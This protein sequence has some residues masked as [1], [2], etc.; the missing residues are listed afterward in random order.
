[1]SFFKL[2]RTS[3]LLCA[4]ALLL[5]ACGIANAATQPVDLDA[6]AVNGAES[7][8]ELNVLA[9]FPVQIEN[10]VTNRTAGDAFT[11]SWPSA[12]PG[13]FSSSV[14][15]GTAGGVGA[16]WVWTTNQSVFAFTGASCV[17]DACFAKTSGPDTLSGFCSDA[18]LGDATTINVR[19]GATLGTVDISWTGGTGTF[20][21]FR[22]T[23]KIAVVAP[24]NSVGT[25][26]TF[27]FTDTPPA[28]APAFY[29]VRGTDCSQRKACASSNDCSGPSDGTCISRGPFGVPGR[30]LLAN[31]V[32]V[33][34]ASLTS[35]LITFF[36]PPHT[37]F[38]ATSEGNAGGTLE[39]FANSSTQPLTVTVPAYPPGCCPAN[40]AVPHQLRCGDTCVDYLN[41]PQNCGSC[42]NVCGDGTC[43]SNG[44]C[45][46]LCGDDRRW[47][48]GECADLA[49][50]SNSCGA[51]GNVC[52]DGTCCD[53]A[54]CASICP[55]GQGWCDNHC[56]DLA[57]DSANCGIC[58]S[59]CGAG[60]CCNGGA[61]ASVCPAWRV[62]CN[63]QCVD[64]AND[65]ANCGACGS[66][67]GAGSCCSAGTCAAF[68]N[69]GRQ[70]CGSECVD[71]QNDSD[72]CGSC[73]NAC[74]AGSCCNGG[75]CVSVCA[76]GRVW[77]NGECVDLAG[78]T[79]NCGAC[80]NSCGGNGCCNA[81]ACVNVCG[82][83]KTAVNGICYDLQNDPNNCGTVGQAC[84]DNTVC[85]AGACVACPHGQNRAECDN[86][87]VNLNTDPYNCGACGN[88]CNVGCP[89]NFHG[90]CSNGR[91]CNC[92]EG[93]PAP[94]PPPNYQNPTPAYCPNL[95]PSDGVA[96]VCPNP[97]PSDGTAG[98][99]S[100]PHPA[101]PTAGVCP[102]PNPSS[103]GPGVCPNPTPSSG[104]IA[105]VCPAENSVTA[106]V[107]ET[108]ICE[109]E[110][111]SVTVPPG[112]TS[113]ICHPG[114]VLFK[115]VPT[116]LIVCGDGIPGV[117]G[118]CNATTT[119]ITTG[120]F[121]RLLPDGTKNAGDAYVTPYAVHIV[122][123]TS[124]DGLLEPGES[125]NL[126][127]DVVNAG[128]KNITG[129]VATL[130]APTVD[131]TAD[132]VTNPVGITVGTASAAYGTI[133]GTPSSVN[134][135]GPPVQPA[136]NATVFPITVPE[137]HPGDTGHPFV[138]NVT[139]TVD[140]NPFSMS[141]PLTIG[142]A[143]KCDVTTG[144]K[145]FDGVDGLSSPMARLVPEGEPVPMAGPFTAGNSRPLRLRLSCG[146]VNL[147]D[148]M[149]DAP[150]IVG[151][152]EATLGALDI[153]VLNLNADN[154]TN[155]N[156][157]FFKFNNALTGGQWAY[158]IRTALL[159]PGTYTL[160]IR[161]AGRKNYVTGFVL[162]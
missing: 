36:S 6:Q 35:S 150:E 79:D 69:D 13:G 33:S 127:I 124:N 58:G 67:C 156:D 112:G 53:D 111:F 158:N 142:I 23:T 55:S 141:V 3:P 148:G 108:P 145:D 130:S 12:G 154:G 24:S 133:P 96:G 65:S 138:L 91:S 152:K 48:D 147:T 86:R 59:A 30:S 38:S 7:A 157:P 82:A 26:N 21:V 118:V 62:F 76:A 9:S 15:P 31:D 109:I 123:D 87:C 17:T 80:G 74:G 116:P 132:G 14:T 70:L 139:G 119:K 94:Q 115:E 29:V 126:V 39:T 98:G 68:C 114:G 45:V 49:N 43:C 113:T 92:I 136:S 159:G 63:G 101:N 66:S 88:S 2:L 97:N 83:G 11:F 10:K 16:K 100:N 1:M 149:V 162:N 51:C 131:L 102:N 52:G 78:D 106:A 46:S 60:T 107:P 110:P 104:P 73:G 27:T 37:V 89:S 4:C 93:S 151:L 40:P 54:S 85:T 18:C 41:D 56:V 135:I 161:I 61:C 32:T 155:P 153:Q 134:C 57:N 121:N 28:T 160:T 34:A 105:G 25:T 122:S 72:N 20:T 144:G 128:T 44:S 90:V 143:D 129:A 42:G 71:F 47:C 120:T 81:G 84:P 140:G 19:K 50:D 8:C 146:G 64:P 75:T 103:P 5:L 99:C 117:N 125:A 77:C 22:G 137:T 95:H